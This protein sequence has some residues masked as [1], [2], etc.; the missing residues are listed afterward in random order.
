[1]VGHGQVPLFQKGATATI[2]MKQKGVLRYTDKATGRPVMDVPKEML[3]AWLGKTSS[4][5]A[6]RSVSRWNQGAMNQ[7]KGDM[8]RSQNKEKADHGW[9][10]IY[11]TRYTHNDQTCRCYEC[12]KVVTDG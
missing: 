7:G 6:R 9:L 3:G 1:M 11:C 2:M 8:Y 12:R 4:R 10:T 5:T